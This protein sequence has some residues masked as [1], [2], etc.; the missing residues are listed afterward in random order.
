MNQRHQGHYTWNK[1]DPPLAIHRYNKRE[2][3]TRV[4]PKA[5][6]FKVLSTNMQGNHQAN[7]VIDPITGASLEYRHIIKGPTKIIWEKSPANETCRLAQG[8]GTRMPWGTNA[9]FFTPKEKVPAGRT[10]T[11]GIIVAEIRPKK[12]E[13]HCTRLTVGENL[14]IFPGYVTTLTADLITA[15]LIFNS[16]LSTKM[17]NSYLQTYPTS[18]LT[19]PWTDMSILS[20]HWKLSQMK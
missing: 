20:Y 16:V 12:A 9:I 4:E 13:T 15:R 1:Y 5:Q 8:V 2:Q 11:Y 6:H 10:V 17:K 14:I 18:I 7:V 3:G 19:I